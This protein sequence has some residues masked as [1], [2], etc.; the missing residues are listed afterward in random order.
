MSY[1]TTFQSPYPFII[2]ENYREDKIIKLYTIEDG[3]FKCSNI[4]NLENANPF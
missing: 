1:L 3:V 2:D 4:N